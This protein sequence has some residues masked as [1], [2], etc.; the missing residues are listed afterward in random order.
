MSKELVREAGYHC[1]GPFRDVKCLLRTPPPFDKDHDVQVCL[2]GIQPCPG[3]ASRANTGHGVGVEDEL[4]GLVV[5]RARDPLATLLKERRDVVYEGAKLRRR[6]PA[7]GIDQV[8]RNR[9]RL[10]LA[11]EPHQRAVS[12]GVAGLIA[13]ETR[14]AE[15]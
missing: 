8:D 9:G 6:M 3:S 1:V 5:E 10:V 2:A 13:Q 11:Q 14:D 4:L 7:V 12:Q 15:A